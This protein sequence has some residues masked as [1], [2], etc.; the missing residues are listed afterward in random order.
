MDEH[1]HEQAQALQDQ[2]VANAIAAAGKAKEQS[3][4][5][6]GHCHWCGDITGGGRRFCDADCRSDYQARAAANKRAGK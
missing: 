6:T 3:L 5:Y 4:T 1:Y 2:L